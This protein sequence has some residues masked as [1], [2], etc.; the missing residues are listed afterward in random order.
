MICFRQYKAVLTP[1]SGI[2]GL[3]INVVFG[4]VIGAAG[5]LY[6]LFLVL[7]YVLE[8][9]NVFAEAGL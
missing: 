6:D 3:V 1:W 7:G 2:V 8:N 4:G 5:S 9:K